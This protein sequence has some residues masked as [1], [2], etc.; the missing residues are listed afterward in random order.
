MFRL[1]W[2]SEPC[3]LLR[4][5][6]YWFTHW[7]HF[8]VQFG[9]VTFAS[10][11]F[12]LSR[13]SATFSTTRVTIHFVLVH[14]VLLFQGLSYHCVGVTCVTVWA[15]SPPRHVRPVTGPQPRAGIPKIVRKWRPSLSLVPLS[16]PKPRGMGGGE[17]RGHTL[18]SSPPALPDILLGGGGRL[19][20]LAV[21]HL[22]S[23]GPGPHT[24]AHTY[25]RAHTRT[26]TVTW[27][28]HGLCCAAHRTAK[29]PGEG[30]GG[31]GGTGHC[32]TLTLR[33]DE[34]GRGD[35]RGWRPVLPA[36]QGG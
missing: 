19:T 15:A 13:G 16:L 9:S 14:L 33:G 1:I 32:W 31:A 22:R 2:C 4:E 11:V 27:S 24:H 21:A 10:L 30:R 17:K 36:R 28:T 6:R 20:H 12:T 8:K 26:H 35:R 25:A 34:R 5:T 23:Q 7:V 3:L 29:L 18:P